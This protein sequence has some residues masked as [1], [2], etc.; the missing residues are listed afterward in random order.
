MVVSF[1]DHLRDPVSDFL[2][3][4][5]RPF[6]DS[7]GM[8]VDLCRSFLGIYLALHSL[9][10][11]FICILAGILSLPYVFLLY[12]MKSRKILCWSSI[13]AGTL[14]C[15]VAYGSY[16]PLLLYI[17]LFMSYILVAKGPGQRYPWLVF[18]VDI[19]FLLSWFAC[20]LIVLS[21]KIV[22]SQSLL[23]FCN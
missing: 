12:F 23:L 4:S 15:V 11:H 7:I 22:I 5:L 6:C 18:F 2:D 16:Q 3:A 19:V 21:S 20:Y 1:I 13:V 9:L 14:C 8:S 17:L 10:S